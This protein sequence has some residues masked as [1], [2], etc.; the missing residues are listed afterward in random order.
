MSYVVV[1]PFHPEFFWTSKL[2]L[3]NLADFASSL[4]L[5]K[6]INGDILNSIL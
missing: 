3:S 5:S 2:D 4:S 6:V 1:K